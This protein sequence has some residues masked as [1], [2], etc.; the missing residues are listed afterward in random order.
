VRPL[1]DDKILTDWNAL[2][3]AAY[4]RA[5]FVFDD[6]SFAKFARD[7]ISFIENNLI[8]NS[9]LLHRYRNGN[10]AIDAFADDYA[11]LIWALIECY[12][13]TFESEYLTKA[14]YWN[15][16]FIKKLWDAEEGGFFFSRSED[17]DAMGSQKLIYDGATPSANSVALMNLL[18][19][20][21]FTG[22]AV[23]ATRAD[24]MMKLFGRHYAEYGSHHAQALQALQF[25][26][27]PSQE[28]VLSEAG[29]GEEVNAFV[30]ELRKRYLPNAI[31]MKRPAEGYDLIYEFSD[32]IKKQKP[33]SNKTTA[34]ICENFA[35]RQPVNSSSEFRRMLDE[36]SVS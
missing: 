24:E 9:R 22:N 3:I 15:N 17:A 7:G 12:Q 10:A 29:D 2:M 16:E 6:D 11:Y 28:I 30:E 34:F 8:S 31:L 21:K 32:F 18:K 25:T 14:I 33:Q 35:C 1:L 5:A 20:H 19:L 26:M 36:I 4:A 23:Y 27:M 13:S